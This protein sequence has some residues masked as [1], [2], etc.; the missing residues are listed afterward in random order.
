MANRTDQPPSWPSPFHDDADA[1]PAQLLARA[2]KDYATQQAATHE[3]QE[4]GGPGVRQGVLPGG[5]H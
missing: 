2:A 4:Q 3:K 1:I 5:V